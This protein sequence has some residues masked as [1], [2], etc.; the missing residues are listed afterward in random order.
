MR[1]G[2]ERRRAERGVV[3]VQPQVSELSVG[4]SLLC[5]WRPFGDDDSVLAEEM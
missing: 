4:S 1:R 3:T 5:F 2:E